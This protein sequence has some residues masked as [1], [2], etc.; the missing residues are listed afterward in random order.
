[1]VSPERWHQ[2]TDIVHEA[3]SRDLAEMDDYVS[4]V[5]GDDLE[6]RGLVDTLIRNDRRAGSTLNRPPILDLPEPTPLPP[7]TPLGPYTI[8]GLIATGGMGEV[9]RASDGR[10]PRTVAIKVLPPHLNDDAQ[11]RA[12]F[13]REARAIGALNHPHICTLHDI[14]RQDGLDFLVMEFIEGEPL[15]GWLARGR[16]AIPEAVRITREVADALGA[17]HARG[18]VHRDIKPSNIMI[19]TGG[20]VKVV[21]FGIARAVAPRTLASGAA[22]NSTQPGIIIGTPRYMSP[23]QALGEPLD[24]RSDVFSLGVVLFEC[25]TGEMPFDGTTRENYARNMIAGRTRS[26]ADLNPQIPARLQ[27][28][29]ARCLATDRSKRAESG[30]VLA[31]ELSHIEQQVLNPRVSRRYLWWAVAALCGAAYALK[32]AGVAVGAA[33]WSIRHVPLD[34]IPD[35]S[36]TQ[37]IVYSR[38]DRSPDVIEDQV[39]YP[40]VAETFDFLNDANGEHVKSEHVWAAL[41]AATADQRRI[42]RGLAEGGEGPDNGASLDSGIGGSSNPR[43]VPFR[44][45]YYVLRPERRQ[46]VNGLVYPV[47]DPAFPF[48]GIHTTLRPDGS[49]WLGP[50]IGFNLN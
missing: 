47:P 5:C 42:R 43:I 25:L 16:I 15:S 13:E 41:D 11:V 45:D 37:V 22:T 12:R 3:L 31:A 7:G 38:W 48:L 6:L 40:I 35:L 1:M 28:L 50:R 39:T 17:A 23:E 19:T 4:K 32:V 8:E 36:D 33:V 30:G 2:A 20:S 24:A 21:D 34:A 46:L 9:Y 26:A 29:L 18:L 14:G 49:V 27:A 10:I 44:G